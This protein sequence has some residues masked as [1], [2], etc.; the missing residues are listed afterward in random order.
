MG[1]VSASAAAAAPA[2]L[3]KTAAATGIS[4]HSGSLPQALTTARASGRW[5]IVDVYAT[6]CGP[7]H[8]MD[9]K[10]WSREE[11]ARALDDAH[12][13][14]YVPLRRD[15]ESGEGLEIARRYHVVGYPTLLVLDGKGAEVDR[16]MGFV[17]PKELIATLA[18][19]RSGRGTLA[20]LERELAS[21]KAGP[22]RQGLSLEVGS[23]HAMRGDVRA[24]AELR[25]VAAHDP[26]GKQAAP[27][28]LTLGK[29]YYLRG[30]HDYAA[31]LTTLRE[32]VTRFPSSDEAKEAPYDLGLALHS[33]GK[34]QE[35]RA[36][37]DRWIADAP[38]DGERY[39][40]YA[41]LSFKNDFDRPRGIAVANE[42]LK[43]DPKND[44]L[45]DTLA[46]LY[47]ATGRPSEAAKAE[48][49]AL[50]LK[51]GDHYY[52][53]QLRRFGGAR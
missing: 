17:E 32:L 1:A 29:Y 49:K 52:Q 9:E 2:A 47:A 12:G 36:T 20:E 11:V 35:A 41:W 18:S 42:G 7:C 37:L 5:V 4:W 46:E 13:G 23:R 43:M 3:P 51:P 10:V 39:N 33:L 16:L 22:A 15:G 25:E 45:W 50:A 24:V 27:A 21:A 6:W 34:D 30:Q 31:A 26:A 38:K 19:F 28:L 40:A 53:A 48:A 44:G 8:E 14:P